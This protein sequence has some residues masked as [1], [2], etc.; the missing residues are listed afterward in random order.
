MGNASTNTHGVTESRISLLQD[1][2]GVGVDLLLGRS[3]ARNTIVV[4]ALQRGTPTQH[5]S[6]GTVE[7]GEEG[8]S[9]SILHGLCPEPGGLVGEGVV[10]L[11]TVVRVGIRCGQLTDVLVARA[12]DL[13]GNAPGRVGGRLATAFAASLGVGADDALD[14]VARTVGNA[15]PREE[16]GALVR[17]QGTGVDGGGGLDDGVGSR[18]EGEGS[19]PGVTLD[20]SVGIGGGCSQGG[21]EQSG[22]LGVL[23]DEKNDCV[24]RCCR[25][26]ECM[27][28]E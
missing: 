6:R 3:R 12:V 24:G 4:I 16:V 1:D 15:Q 26:N 7:A 5:G 9:N 17:G 2:S 28:K 11:D 27:F 14:Q 21:G 13:G 19:A 22:D 8:T 25:A 23:H 20:E 10:Q 18:S